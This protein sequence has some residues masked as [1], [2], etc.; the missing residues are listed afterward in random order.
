MI[1]D[2]WAL[3]TSAGAF[4][5]AAREMIRAWPNAAKHHLNLQSGRRAWIGQATCCHRHGATSEETAAAWGL[6]ANSLQRQANRIASTVMDDYLQG[7]WP[8][9]QTLFGD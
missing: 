4:E 2:S 1:H 8:S 5:R 6:M 3:L 7:R 9:A